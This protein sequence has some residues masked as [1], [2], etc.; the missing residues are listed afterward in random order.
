MKKKIIKLIAFIFAVLMPFCAFVI[1]TES[2]EDTYAK[3]YLGGFEAKYDRLYSVEG[4]KIVF[5]G[6]SSLPFGLRSDLIA[7]ELGGEYTVVNYGLYATLGTKFMMDTAKN[8]IGEGDIVVLCP[9]LNAQTYSLYFNPEATLQATNGFSSMNKALDA[10]D[11][12]SLFYNYYKYAFDKIG[13]SFRGDAPDPAG[14]YRADSLNSYGEIEGERDNNIMNNGYDANMEIYTDDSLLNTEFTEYVNEYT[15][16]AREK[17]ATVY[18][19]YSPVNCLAIRSSSNARAEFEEKL[20]SMIECELLGS[21]EDY[22]IDERYFYDTNFHLNSAGAVYF[23]N[24]TALLLKEKLGMDAVTSIEVPAPPALEGDE[25]V[26]VEQGEEKLDF[27]EYL[28]EPNIDYADCFIY[29]L[30]GSSYT[31]VGVKEEHRGIREIILPS[32]YNGKN[33][34]AVGEKAFYG[35]SE[36]EYIHIGNTYKSLSKSS[37]SGCVSLK[38]VYLYAMDGNR[39]LPPAEDLLLGAPAGIKILIPEGSNYVS[40]YTWSN[41]IDSFDTFAKEGLK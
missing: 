18:F 20:S 28:G 12:T 17:G 22:L 23:S 37:F 19:N 39:I 8:S 16:Y 4:K 24:M 2:L 14:I 6:G 9:E 33:V 21:I 26:D 41:Y 38:G 13:Y 32:V 3:T 40:G 31:V 30:S 15:R 11:K 36:L 29:E 7:E 5:I 34:T 35:C 10:D 27:S 25:V 1:I